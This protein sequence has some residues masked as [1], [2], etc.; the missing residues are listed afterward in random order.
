[1]QKYDDI[2]VGS[3]I[4]GLTMALILGMN[5][6]KV[7]LLEK[8]P[9]IGG[10]VSRFYKK[11]VPFDTGFHFTGGLHKNGL[12]YDM[13]SVLGIRD[14]IQPVFL[15]EENANSFFFEPEG[16]LYEIPY[17]LE[18][19][20]KKFKDYF[21]GEVSALDRYF[22]KVQQVCANTPSMNLQALTALHS[23]M[24]EDFLS[25]DEVLNG[26]TG[27]PVLKALLSGF[28]MCYGV[29][30]KEISFANHSRM[31]LGLYESVARVKDGGEAFIKA[32]EAKFKSSDIEI[33]CGKYI[34]RLEDVYNKKVG[35]FILNT[36]E[37]VTAENCIFTIHPGEILKVLPEQ[38]LSK[39]FVDRVT[40]FESSAG[41]FTV[42]AVL[43]EEYDEPDF[44]S[45]ILSIFPHTDVNQLL[46][47]ANTGAS[48]L[49]IIKSIEEVKGK[50]YKTINAFE[51]SFI[52]HVENWKDSKT[53]R[54]SQSYGDY[55]EER[56]EN[57]TG[58]I[59]NAFPRYKDR[60]KVINSASVLTFRDYLNSPDGSAYGVKQ[61]IGQ[62]NL[63]GK[64]PLRNL[65]AA[66]QS[67]LLPGI[68]GAMMSSFLVG[69]Y[70]L[71]EEQYNKFLSK[72]LS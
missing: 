4:S 55:K 32:F 44:N 49:V 28:A 68:M 22:E 24:N 48:A 13:L 11:G 62:Y 30:P 63:I 53:G 6:R 38:H 17:G 12:L 26:L 34:A 66:G 69:R 33:R 67:S 25:L 39:A 51:P 23:P 16:R 71:E 18:K 60:I 65:Y 37:E 64:L 19:L 46:D 7:L 10:S 27:N 58:R 72:S 47:P 8:S 45:N 57:I 36:G 52:E 42:F 29:M 54:R 15:S 50:I 9:R 3:G 43:D 5:G 31:C 70:I 35:R 61:K 41:F 56:V 21:P 1:M 14:L 2:V 40:S 20:K 59:Y